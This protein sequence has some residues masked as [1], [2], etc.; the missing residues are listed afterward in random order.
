MSNHH[1]RPKRRERFGAIFVPAVVVVSIVLVLI[2]SPFYQRHLKSRI[3]LSRPSV[4]GKVIET[5]IIVVGT[6]PQAYRSGIIEYRAEAHVIYNLNGVQ[7]DAW[8]PASS[9]ETDRAYLAF[10]L[11][12][13]KSK[14][15]LIYWSPQTLSTSRRF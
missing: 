8:V 3:D 14:Q 7:H 1:A 15:A 11:F 9:V 4:T 6:Q 13:N 10:W 12:L 2:A 5:R